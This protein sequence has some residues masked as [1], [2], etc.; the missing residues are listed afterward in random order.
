LEKLEVYSIKALKSGSTNKK[1]VI[2]LCVLTNEQ[3][4]IW[5]KVL[6]SLELENKA[7]LILCKVA[8]M[9]EL[10]LEIDRNKAEMVI[11]RETNP[12]AEEKSLVHLMSIYPRL[13]IV[14]ASELSNWLR[15]F[16]K[17]EIRLTSFTDLVHLINPD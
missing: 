9:P 14:V 8:S 17:D 6:S 5:N 4:S 10:I 1:T 12:L 3:D 7:T 16:N 11:F 13:R 2:T 15:V